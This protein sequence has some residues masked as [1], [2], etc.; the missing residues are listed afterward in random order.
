M[1]SIGQNAVLS[2][3]SFKVGVDIQNITPCTDNLRTNS[4]CKVGYINIIGNIK[5][6]GGNA[7]TITSVESDLEVR[8][9]VIEDQS[10]TRVALI[11]IDNLGLPESFTN[12]VRTTLAASGLGLSENHIIINASHTHNAPAIKDNTAAGVVPPLSQE[13][14]PNVQYVAGVANK[15]VVCVQNAIQSLQTASLSISN[16][17][18]KIAMYRR[19]DGKTSTAVRYPQRVDVLQAKDN[20]GRIIAL[21]YFTGC[22]STVMFNAPT[23]LSSDFGGESRTIIENALQSTSPNAKVLFFQEFA[24]DLQSYQLALTPSGGPTAKSATAQEISNDVLSTLLN[25]AIPLTD[26][27]SIIQQTMQLPLDLPNTSWNNDGQT[28]LSTALTELRFAGA[29]PWYFVFSANEVVGEYASNLRSTYPNPFNVTLAGYNNFVNSYLPTQRMITYDN[30]VCALLPSGY[31]GCFSFRLNYLAKPKWKDDAYYVNQKLFSD[32]FD[33]DRRDYDKWTLAQLPSASNGLDQAVTVSESNQRLS[34]NPLSNTAGFHY[35]GYASTHTYNF[36]NKQI[37]LEIIQIPNISSTSEFL[38]MI[39]RETGD[40]YFAFNIQTGLLRA[41]KKVAGQ[42]VQNFALGAYSP[43]THRYLRIRNSSSLILW[44]ASSDGISWNTLRTE[45][46]GINFAA[47]RVYLLAGTYQSTNAPGQVIVDNFNVANAPL[48]TFSD[49]F[50]D[51][52]LDEE[53]WQNYTMLKYNGV[54]IF[55]SNIDVREIAQQLRIISLVSTTGLN[56]GGYSSKLAYNLGNEQASIRVI[57]I[58]NT[59]STAECGF[60]AIKDKDNF[61]G[62]NIQSGFLRVQKNVAGQSTYVALGSFNIQTQKYLRFRHSLVSNIFFWEAS[63]D[64]SVWSTLYQETPAF[65][66]T[67]IHFEVLAGT[68]QAETTPGIVIF[69]NF[70]IINSQGFFVKK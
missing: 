68:Y 61:Y 62:F 19:G 6:S 29:N 43:S 58:P 42:A 9:I 32:N 15:I 27:F 33:D 25:S 1:L 50:N 28:T 67:A 10:M 41:D 63:A 44:E 24:G 3:L 69:D 21:A 20:I 49:D 7:Q 37:S 11:T 38:M 46:A 4:L 54:S 17:L 23:Q 60:L 26:T 22:H 12:S 8:A 51:N 36:N 45:T 34:I 70:N 16:A 5:N 47:M 2:Q 64:G 40:N 59:A 13:D 48:T 53:K 18:T 65:P 52:L 30:F 35:N 57:Q 39:S 14:P 66:L 55:N 31:E 56:Y